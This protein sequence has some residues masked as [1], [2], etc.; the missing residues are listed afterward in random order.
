MKKTLITFLAL[1]MSLALNAQQWTRTHVD[2]DELKGTKE[3]YFLFYN[4]NAFSLL[5]SETNGDISFILKEG[6]LNTR[7]SSY[8]W[9]ASILFGLYDADGKELL[10][11]LDL[12]CN[13]SR[14]GKSIRIFGSMNKR[15]CK[16]IRQHLNTG[17]LRI[18]ADRY[19]D[20]SLDVIV[21][22]L[23]EDL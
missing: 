23:P 8:N 10:D 13:A 7:Y 4:D 1:M 15:I 18:V 6:I 3:G 17:R 14:D 16:T 12:S 22:M 21:P 2:A 20:S 5:I 11:K 9:R 19:S